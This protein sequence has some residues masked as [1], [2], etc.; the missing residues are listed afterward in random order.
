MIETL[1]YVV[2]FIHVRMCEIF[3][4]ISTSLLSD[5]LVYE[6]KKYFRKES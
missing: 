6:E 4:Y 5:L 1:Y 2:L 3:N